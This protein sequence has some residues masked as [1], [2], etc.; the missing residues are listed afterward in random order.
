MKLAESTRNVKV[1]GAENVSAFGVSEEGMPILLD[2]M[3]NKIYSDK[4]LAIIREYACNAWDANVENGNGDKPIQ[5]F[6]PNRM[7][8]VLKIRDF[9]K[10][11]SPEEI[12]EIYIMYGNSTKR[13][14]NEMIGML[15]IGSKSA[16]AYGDS[17][18]ITSFNDGKKYVY[19]AFRDASKR[20]EMAQLGKAE[21]TDEPSGIEIQIPI[22]NEDIATILKKAGQF[23]QHWDL[24]P[25]FFGAEPTFKDRDVALEGKGQGLENLQGRPLRL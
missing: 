12:R 24:R 3:S 6:L 16:F 19:S 21:K 13:Q 25:E 17:F 1:S 8:P 20:P 10:G 11:L 23:F 9:G 4:P 7:E 14:S 15:G 18:V 2:I 5:V 22:R